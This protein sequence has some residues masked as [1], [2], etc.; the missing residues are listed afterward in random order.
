M[1]RLFACFLALLLATPLAAHAQQA[2]PNKPLKLIVPYPAAGSTDILGRLI[3]QKLSDSLGQPIVVDNRSGAGGNIG[4]EVV[5]RSAPDGYTLLIGGAQ[6]TINATLYKNLSFD[7]VKDL[8]PFAIVGIVPNIMVVPNSVPAKTPKEFIAWAKAQSGG[9]NYASSG[10]GATTHMSAELF[11]L[12]TGTSMTHVPYRGSAPALTDLISGRTQVMFDNLASALP[13]VKAGSLRALALT[14]PNRSPAIPDLPTLKE[15]G[16][17]VEAVSW[18][19][20]FLPSGTSKE[21]VDRLNREVRRIVMQP[22]VKAHLA[23]LGADPR[24]WS[25]QQIA[26]FANSEVKKW[27]KVI[28]VSG[29]KVE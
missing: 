13:Q 14:G 15:S 11:K 26:E 18:F 12:A 22:D 2:Y 7:F 3:A 21:I 29:A 4:T 9:V 27:A 5:A 10:N 17:D 20:L 23:Q 6:N 1:N 24:D 25:P 28:Q 19:G 16:V 8:T